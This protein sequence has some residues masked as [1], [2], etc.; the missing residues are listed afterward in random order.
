MNISRD[1]HSSR[2][3]LKEIRDSCLYLFGN[4]R[5]AAEPLAYPPEALAGPE[6]YDSSEKVGVARVRRHVRMVMAVTALLEQPHVVLRATVDPEHNLATCHV[7]AVDVALRPGVQRPVHQPQELV[8][9]ALARPVRH[10]L[11]DVAAV[12]PV[13]LPRL[14]NAYHADRVPAAPA[15]VLPATAPVLRLQIRVTVVARVQQV[16]SAI[17]TLARPSRLYHY[18]S[19]G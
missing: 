11:L 9:V 17:R 18:S 10:L 14:V 3:I 15:E 19:F 2:R 1:K 4:I 16:Q 5:H 7:Q 6:T 8:V 13:Q 12:E